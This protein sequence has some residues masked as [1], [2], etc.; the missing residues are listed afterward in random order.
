MAAGTP[1]TL[2]SLAAGDGAAHDYYTVPSGKR[3]RVVHLHFSNHGS[4]GGES[5]SAAIDTGSSSISIVPLQSLAQANT[6]DHYSNVGYVLIA[7]QSILGSA[8]P[9][10]SFIALGYEEAV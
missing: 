1:K 5:I 8:G 4:S 2:V 7:G 9:N 6:Y 10:T 3:T